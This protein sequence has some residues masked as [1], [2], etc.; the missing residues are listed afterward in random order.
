MIDPGFDA[1]KMQ[2]RVIELIRGEHYV[3]FTDSSDALP[4]EDTVEELR[5]IA[6]ARRNKETLG[7]AEMQAI[8]TL[9]ETVAT[10]IVTNVV[11]AQCQM[12]RDYVGKLRSRRRERIQKA[13]E[14]A[15]RAIE[16]ARDAQVPVAVPAGA[17][18]T[19][20]GT[21]DEGTTWRVSCKAGDK[22]VHIE[23]DVSGAVIDIMIS[24][25]PAE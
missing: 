24:P 13:Q 9:A 16:A 7:P 3:V 2:S 18:I 20:S 15:G 19:V 25:H 8:E 14:A 12:A 10:G 22:P 6:Y 4:D 21:G 23:M 5:I 17:H 11:W 1:E